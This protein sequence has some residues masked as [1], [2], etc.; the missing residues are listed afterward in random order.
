MKG[1]AFT[2]LVSGYIE[3]VSDHVKLVSD[4]VSQLMTLR[5]T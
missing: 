5:L 1:D 4:H 2:R 3:L